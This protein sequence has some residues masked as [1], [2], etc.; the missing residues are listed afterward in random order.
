[1]TTKKIQKERKVKAQTEDGKFKN[2]SKGAIL[3]VISLLIFSLFLMTTVSAQPQTNIQVSTADNKIQISYPKLTI[4]EINK[5]FKVNFRTFNVSSGK[6][7]DNNSMDC[8]ISLINKSGDIFYQEESEYNPS[9]K[10][11]ENKINKSYFD[12]SG[13]YRYEILCIDGEIDGFVSGE[14][15]VTETGEEEFDTTYAIIIL[16]IS[17]GTAFIGFFGKNIW[18][19]VIGG[20]IM[21]FFGIYTMTNGIVGFNN[22]LTEV[23]SII[24]IGLGFFFTLYPLIEWIEDM[25]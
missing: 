22:Q 7:L 10:F 21:I 6:F 4:Q 25:F 15:K 12:E 17:F 1:M 13:N 14:Y 18:V 2:L 20:I 24:S 9:I 16:L 8:N 5:N 11:W 19:T 3:P 23:I